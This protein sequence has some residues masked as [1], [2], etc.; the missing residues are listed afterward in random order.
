MLHSLLTHCFLAAHLTLVSW[1][2]Q[3]LGWH[4][5]WPLT[6][7][8]PH[9]AV[10][11]TL[12]WVKKISITSWEMYTLFSWRIIA[13]FWDEFIIFS[14]AAMPFYFFLR[15][16]GKLVCS[17]AVYRLMNSEFGFLPFF[18][19]RNFASTSIMSYLLSNDLNGLFCL[20]LFFSHILLIA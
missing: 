6:F 20:I 4:C 19:S 14:F 15:S 16:S 9:L 3:T 18:F 5:G 8:Q 10:E 1:I 17:S 2:P 13:C 11:K 7:H 12:D